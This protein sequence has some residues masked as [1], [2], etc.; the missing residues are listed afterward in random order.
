MFDFIKR[1]RLYK[2]FKRV[3]KYKVSDSDKIVLMKGHRNKYPV[4]VKLYTVYIPKVHADF[5]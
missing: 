1:C 4:Q 5:V 3:R 2:G